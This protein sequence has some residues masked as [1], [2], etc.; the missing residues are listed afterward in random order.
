MKDQDPMFQSAVNRKIF[1]VYAG[2]AI[3]GL[4]LIAFLWVTQNKLKSRLEET[5]LLLSKTEAAA[6]QLQKDKARILKDNEKLQ[7]DALSYV[8]LNNELQQQKESLQAKLQ[9]IQKAIEAQKKELAVAQQYLA[10]MQQKDRDKKNSREELVK[11]RDQMQRDL[12]DLEASV[13]RER[14]VYHYNLAVAYT[15][16]TF[17]KKAVQEYEKALEYDPKNEDAHYNLGLLYKDLGD[18]PARALAHFRTYLELKPDAGDAQE[19]R[20]FI[21]DLI[22]RSNRTL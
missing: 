21:D 8:A 22:E 9:E 15:K 12:R 17:M 19:V 14:G 2:L 11:E 3:A 5:R 18:D 7:V 1:Y 20:R 13:N 6:A 4:A 16:A 10:D